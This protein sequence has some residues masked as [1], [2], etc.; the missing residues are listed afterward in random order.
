MSLDESITGDEPLT[1]GRDNLE[2]Y[3]MVME[4]LRKI[5]LCWSERGD[6]AN[7][8]RLL[9]NMGVHNVVLVFSDSSSSA[10]DP[11][12]FVFFG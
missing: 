10:C 11:Y 4:T 1:S 12:L 7:K 2:K 3:R 5:D 8:E 9:N 6:C